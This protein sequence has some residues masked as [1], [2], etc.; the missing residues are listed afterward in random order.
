MN[1][2]VS[3]FLCSS[4]SELL[5]CWYAANIFIDSSSDFLNLCSFQ[6]SCHLQITRVLYFFFHI[7]GFLSFLRLLWATGRMLNSSGEERATSNPDFGVSPSIIELDGVPA[8]TIHGFAGVEA[9]PV[10]R[11]I[12]KRMPNLSKARIHWAL[13]LVRYPP[14]TANHI[15]W[16]VM[17]KNSASSEAHLV[18]MHDL[19]IRWVHSPEFFAEDFVYII[20]TVVS[21]LCGIL[22]R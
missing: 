3:L 22:V 18:I 21:F 17:P 2:I 19:N 7:L 10:S 1:G 12:A 11:S 9:C 8:R 15:D 6:R 13:P 14:M 16:P 20:S 5:P 4:L